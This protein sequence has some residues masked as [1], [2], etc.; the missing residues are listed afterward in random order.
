MIPASSALFRKDSPHRCRGCKADLDV[1]PVS[2]SLAAIIFCGLYFYGERI[3]GME[4]G[5]FIFVLVTVFLL[6]MEFLTIKVKNSGLRQGDTN[7]IE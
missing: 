4:N 2:K 1:S 7:T 6:L 5:F 3:W